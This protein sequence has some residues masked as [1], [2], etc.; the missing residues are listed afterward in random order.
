MKKC[1]FTGSRPEKMPI[2]QNPESAEYHELI[3][4]IR[5]QIKELTEREGVMTFLSGAA[6]GID[7]I[8]AETVLELKKDYP[9][10]TLECVVP[11][12]AQADGWSE[13]HKK[14]YCSILDR[15][16]KVTVLQD[17]YSRGCLQKRNRYLVDNADIVLAVWNGTKGGTEYTIKYARK[18]NK[19][20]IIINVDQNENGGCCAKT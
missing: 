20:L 4:R 18:L 2:L 14:Q 17:N 6:K 16:D 5:T 11:Y 8:A 15:S 12:L 9:E 7:L 1:A 3:S 19:K 10:I 13:E